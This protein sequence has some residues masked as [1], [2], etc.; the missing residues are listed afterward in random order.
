MNDFRDSWPPTPDSSRAT[1]LYQ[2]TT[3]IDELT[4]ALTNHT[5]VPSP[6]PEPFLTCC[7]SRDDCENTK[8]WLAFKAKLEGRLVLSAGVF[9]TCHLLGSRVESKEI[10]L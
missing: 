6:E 8:G 4:L 1:S 2:A 10:V 5:R 3:A 7:C 9:P